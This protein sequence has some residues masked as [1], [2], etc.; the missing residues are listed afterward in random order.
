MAACDFFTVEV[1]KL[2]GIIR[3]YVFFVMR[4]ATREVRIAGISNSPSGTWMEQLGRNL[5]DFEN[6]FLQGYKFLIRDRDLIYSSA[7]LR[8]LRSGGVESI[9]LQRRS[10]NLNAFAEL[11]VRSI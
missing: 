9:R 10:P 4:L 3:Y 11:F 5:T 1:F 7:F 2:G 6:G 8:I